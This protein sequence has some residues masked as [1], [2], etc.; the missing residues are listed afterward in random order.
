MTLIQS[1][2]APPL[3][4]SGASADA[5]RR[6]VRNTLDSDRLAMYFQPIVD[7]RNRPV[8]VEALARIVTADGEVHSPGKF[9]TAIEGTDLMVNFD[10][11]A[12]VLSCVAAQALARETHDHPLFVSCNFSACTLEQPGLAIRVLETI[13]QHNLAPSQICI[14]VTENAIFEAG[15]DELANL[16]QA[17]VR[18]ALDN[19]GTGYCE[20]SS[21]KTL[22]LSMVK[23]DRSYTAALDK[24]GSERALA[25][26]ILSLAQSL[27]LAVV[28]EGVEN[29]RQ[30]RTARDLGLNRMQGWFYSPAL[31]FDE[32]L[33]LLRSVP[34]S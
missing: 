7:A 10:R 9:L 17:G 14:E 11:Q 25:T 34:M 30:W 5:Q 19:F 32:L 29:G 26:T 6:V 33:A 27:K 13:R 12:L 21:L 8:A 3:A 31:P 4:T 2:P 23:I 24:S 20:L 22:P 18:I 28:A 16:R 15:V 1:D